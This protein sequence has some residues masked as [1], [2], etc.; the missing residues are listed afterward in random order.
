MTPT[1]K[2]HL[3]KVRKL[4]IEDDRPPDW[5]LDGR[6]YRAKMVDGTLYWF[7]FLKTHGWQRVKVEDR[8]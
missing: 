4:W 5:V 7:E 8:L 1:E 2:T 6:K 3:A